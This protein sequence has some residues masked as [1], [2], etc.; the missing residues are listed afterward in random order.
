MVGHGL[1]ELLSDEGHEGVPQLQQ[2]IIR[3]HQHLQ[4]HPHLLGTTAASAGSVV[5]GAL[6]LM[7]SRGVVHA[8]IKPEKRMCF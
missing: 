8:D 3:I 4:Q 5:A 7:H 1:P 2:C 6:A